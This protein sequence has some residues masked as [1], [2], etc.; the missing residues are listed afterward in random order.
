MFMAKFDYLMIVYD[1]WLNRVGPRT[2]HGQITP[3]VFHT[4][5]YGSNMAKR[6]LCQPSM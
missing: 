1:E 3:G 5:P 4:S 6:S 2:N